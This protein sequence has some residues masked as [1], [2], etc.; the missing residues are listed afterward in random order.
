MRSSFSEIPVELF[1]FRFVGKLSPKILKL[2]IFNRNLEKMDN[3]S[4]KIDIW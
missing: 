2:D 3:L 1:F 4:K